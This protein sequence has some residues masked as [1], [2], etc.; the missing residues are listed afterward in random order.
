MFETLKT[1]NKSC[2][3]ILTAECNSRHLFPIQIHLV[4]FTRFLR[5][6]FLFACAILGMHFLSL[7][8]R[9][10]PKPKTSLLLQHGIYRIAMMTEPD[11]CSLLAATTNIKNKQQ[12]THNKIGQIFKKLFSNKR[13][14]KMNPRTNEKIISP[15]NMKIVSA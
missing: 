5:L 11:E 3:R 12:H 4:Q 14:M 15:M 8:M 10:H 6:S 9:S 1:S 7:L 2:T 13:N